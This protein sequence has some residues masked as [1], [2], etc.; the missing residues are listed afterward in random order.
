MKK[1]IEEYGEPK[2]GFTARGT[3]QSFAKQWARKYLQNFNH[4]LYGQS[5][6]A[7]SLN[8]I[9]PVDGRQKIA[10]NLTSSL[11]LLGHR[12]ENHVEMLLMH[13]DKS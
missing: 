2:L 13:T 9:V 11:L 3:T 5:N 1:I 10:H 12:D 8:N 4:D 7:Q 6:E